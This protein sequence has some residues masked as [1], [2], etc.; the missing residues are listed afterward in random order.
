MSAIREAEVA[1]AA[2][3]GS[4]PVEAG[5]FAHLQS[6]AAAFRPYVAGRRVLDFGASYGLSMLALA[7]L[8]PVGIVGVEPDRARVL[9]GQAYVAGDLRLALVHVEDTRRLPFPAATFGCVV[10]NAVLEHIP[11]PRAPYLREMWRVL[12]PGGHLVVSETPNA[13]LPWD[14]HTT[15][16]PLLNWLPEG[17]ARRVALAAGRHPTD[18]DWAHSG[19]H[20]VGHREVARCL[21]GHRTIHERTRLRH[22]VLRAFGLP[23]GLLD[24]WPFVVFEKAG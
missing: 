20:G 7:G 13:Y 2:F 15:G 23:T 10:A 21:P 3:L 4:Q 19:W 16:L 24:P 12:Q 9:Q 11:R 18:C 8:N 5:R 14:Y 6:S 22:R 1:F 17:V